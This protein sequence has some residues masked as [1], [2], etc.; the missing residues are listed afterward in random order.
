MAKIAAQGAADPV[1][2]ADRRRLIEAELVRQ[3]GDR[4]RRR[5]RRPAWSGAAS[6]GSTFM[7]A[8]TI[9]DAITSV[10]TNSR[11]RWMA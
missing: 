9:I 10:A 4:V 5:G 1:R 11:I 2:I 3:R 8:N 7:T 6:P